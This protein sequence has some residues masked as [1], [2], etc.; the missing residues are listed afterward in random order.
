MSHSYVERYNQKKLPTASFFKR[1]RGKKKELNFAITVSSCRMERSRRRAK[2]RLFD[3]L[4][5]SLHRQRSK[6]E[7]S[8]W[9]L[10]MPCGRRRL[11]DQLD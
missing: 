5:T 8:Y 4:E 7:E 3:S 11:L 6:F 1:P 10:P 9:H 2:C